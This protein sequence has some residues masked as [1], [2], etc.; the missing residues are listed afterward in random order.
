MT[1]V[2]SLL[3]AGSLITL[4]V[5]PSY[6]PMGERGWGEEGGGDTAFEVEEHRNE[7]WHPNMCFIVEADTNSS[8]NTARKSLL[9]RLTSLGEDLSSAA[10][11]LSCSSESSILLL[12]GD[13]LDHS[14][15]MNCWEKLDV[16]LSSP[17]T[18]VVP[19][20]GKSSSPALKV[21]SGDWRRALNPYKYSE[22]WTKW[23]Y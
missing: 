23:W 10:T 13:Y 5:Q 7:L 12:R 3:L 14:P 19:E 8:Q 9:T 21:P 22:C 6:G 18:T 15:V 1:F 17:C 16:W 2:F 4:T 11:N 20:S